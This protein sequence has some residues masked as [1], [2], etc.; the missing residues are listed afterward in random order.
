MKKDLSPKE[1]RKIPRQ[2]VPERDPSERAHT[3]DEVS[4]GYSPQMARLEAL[5]CLQCKKPKCVLGCPVRVMIPDFIKHIAD[6]DYLGAARIIKES[7][8]LPAVT[9]RVCP[10]EDQC[11]KHC[12]IGLKGEPVA[13]GKL[14]RFAA[15]YE[16][17]HGERNTPEIA[18][19]TGRKVGIVGAG[20]SGLTAAG[21]LA[22]LGHQV[23]VFFSW[24]RINALQ[25]EANGHR[26]I[27][28]S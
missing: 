17:L 8:A 25:K 24:Q 15:D 9:G 23:V 20:P 3:F 6:G 27:K 26:S 11:E 14:E 1:R 28:H 7:N 21:E 12:V 19:A 10:Q 4:L 18:T 2:P 5:R 13:I 16:R 22:K